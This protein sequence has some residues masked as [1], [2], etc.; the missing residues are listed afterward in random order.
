MQSLELRDRACDEQV[1]SANDNAAH[2]N[3]P[4]RERR[5]TLMVRPRP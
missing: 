2:Q 1:L 5:P 3:Y 4:E